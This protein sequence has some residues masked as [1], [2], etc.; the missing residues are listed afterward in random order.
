MQ[1]IYFTPIRALRVL[2]GGLKGLLTASGA[3]HSIVDSIP[4][5]PRLTS[6]HFNLDPITQ[7][8]IVCPSCHHHYP[9]LP[10]DSPANTDE[11]F[12]L[13]CTNRR[14]AES[15]VCGTLL[16]IQRDLGGG[17]SRFI[18][19]R[20]YMHQGLKSWLGRLL[21]RK[22]M[23][24]ILESEPFEPPSPDAPVDDILR[25]NLF[26][27]LKG[28]SGEQFFPAPPGEG[29][30][31]FSL[32]V[33][34]FNPFHNKTAK[35]TVSSTGIWLVLLNLPQHLRY[36]PENM[37]LAGV[38]PADKPSTEDIYP[39]LELVT[40]E[41]LDLWIPGVMFS[42]TGRELHGRLFKAMLIPVVCD[43]L[44]ARQV[45]GL[46]SVTSH[47]F[48]TCC[49]LD[50]DDINVF[51]REE[52]PAKDLTHIRHFAHL[53]RDAESE[54]RRE[55][56]FAASGIRWT[57]LHNLPYWNPILHT[58]VDPMHALDLNLLQN[59]CR[60]LFQIDVKHP[61]G[62]GYTQVTSHREMRI[63]SKEHFRSLK[64]CAEMIEANL[65][66]LR[67]ALLDH[68]RRVL[69]TICVDN[70]ILGNGHRVIVGTKWVL[71]NNILQWV[72]F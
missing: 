2:L 16:W 3:S 35:Q 15:A 26:R 25:S 13:Q 19:V 49:D 9:Y 41:L 37:Y 30:L 58:V 29:R 68:P 40:Q 32:S 17:H 1:N 12:T 59:H 61:G 72:R 33:D 31:V 18:P 56:L 46:G 43:M 20:K 71:A 5:D 47:N 44:A 8:Y 53:W 60:T 21:S 52:W 36:L 67:E 48:C 22:G 24:D 10:G 65:P 55:Q 45:I 51:D 39:Y 27:E 64:K 70:Q 63:T 66:D 11:P 42:R 23:E 38:I 14:A 54:K 6:A 62:D 7:T 57:P 28:P 4:L 50:I 34:S 69:Y